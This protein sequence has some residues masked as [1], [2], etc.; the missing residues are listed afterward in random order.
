MCLCRRVGDLEAID[1]YLAIGKGGM[2]DGEGRS[3]LHYAVAYD[4]A[5]AVQALLAGGADSSVCDKTGN[6]PLHYA[7]GCV[8]GWGAS[9]AVQ[10]AGPAGCR[11]RRR[12]HSWGTNKQPARHPAQQ[13]CPPSATAPT[14]RYGR[15]EC[16]RMLLQSGADV[17]ARND[18]GQT[19]AEV[20]R[21]EPRNPLN[22][23]ATLLAVLDGTAEMD[24]IQ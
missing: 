3:A 5:P 21:G 16:V 13:A 6:P 10:I 18:K 7:A 22:Q 2:T 4:R 14:C 15:E 17:N 9:G 24:S 12:S 8:Q 20:V 1:D 23:N 19:A 11:M